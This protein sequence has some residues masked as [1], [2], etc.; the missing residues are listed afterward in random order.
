M[1]FSN[2]TDKSLFVNRMGDFTDRKKDFIPGVIDAQNIVDQY[3]AVDVVS[4]AED[5]IISPS[6][7]EVEI[8][9][10][11][12]K[13]S[14]IQASFQQTDIRQSFSGSESGEFLQSVADV[15]ENTLVSDSLNNVFGDN[16]GGI[17]PSTSPV[18][19]NSIFT[20]VVEKNGFKKQTEEF[21]DKTAIAFELLK[22]EDEK[23]S[24]SVIDDKT[25]VV[26]RIA[27]QHFR[28]Q[29]DYFR[30]ENKSLNKDIKQLEKEVR[31]GIQSERTVSRQNPKSM[32]S[33]SQSYF[34]D[35]HKDFSDEVLSRFTSPSLSIFDDNSSEAKLQ[36]NT[37]LAAQVQNAAR[38]ETE[39][40]IIEQK[41]SETTIKESDN[42]TKKSIESYFDN[43][44]SDR[45]G[46]KD[47]KFAAKEEKLNSS[48][49]K[50]KSN[51]DEKKK[52]T[53]KAATIAAVANFLRMKKS[54]QNDVGDM[55][56][57]VSGDLLRDGRGFLGAISEG[58]KTFIFTQIKSWIISAISAFLGF[59]VNVLVAFLPL[60]AS[61]VILI[62]IL[63]S[64]LSI[65]SDN[66]DVPD[67]DG[68]TYASISEDEI[69]EI[70]NTLYEEYEN[71]TYEH[72][73][74]CRYL[75]SK[76]GCEYDQGYHWSLTE[77]I[78]DCSSLAYRSYRE[79]NLNI[80]NQ[81]VYTASEECRMAVESGHLA[82]GEIQPGDLIFY[83][84]S[85]NGRYLG[86]YHVA[87]YIGDGKMV[88]ARGK[89]WGVVYCDVRTSNV[90]AYGRYL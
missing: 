38:A 13:E 51:N 11:E 57:E 25:L 62:V 50:K 31:S 65:F 85:N 17:P 37:A 89:S 42:K 5:I 74:L 60:L 49:E 30:Q 79:I 87:I 68:Y 27:E 36:E 3:A 76:V 73:V 59:I 70:I 21:L 24:A 81:G 45:S 43:K 18:Y 14:V 15:Y 8:P 33:S 71:M 83:G 19:D 10:E 75:L 9:V 77:D 46:K 63:T 52:A 34:V 56:G 35:K 41:F 82:D 54:F 7:K 78:F 69:D 66:V 67:G 1:P 90:V 23:S 20:D 16:A 4:I 48:K 28:E 80:S 39:N 58:I 26:T 2:K 44:E 22:K 72:E 88:E 6:E 40:N 55:S 12:I 53:K 86:V 47:D 84:G 32:F 29:A 61:L 64:F